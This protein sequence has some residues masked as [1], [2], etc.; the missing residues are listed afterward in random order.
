L[1]DIDGTVVV[2]V[3]GDPDTLIQSGTTKID[4]R[5][6]LIEEVIFPE[7]VIPQYLI[8]AAGTA[9]VV[10]GNYP[11][12]SG[13]YTSITLPNN[14]N[15][16]E[17]TGDV[18]IYVTGNLDMANHTFIKINAGSSLK[19]YIDG[20]ISSG[21]ECSFYNETLIPANFKI[22][23]TSTTSQSFDL[24]PNTDFYGVIYAPNADIWIQPNGDW[25]GACMC[26]SF[27]GSNNSFNF[28]YDKALSSIEYG[29]PVY[30]AVARWWED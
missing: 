8:D 22:F 2:G 3:G 1:I 4:E 12:V 18:E 19:I 6:A 9:L 20:N 5:A 24:W 17:I 13:K 27:Y 11:L 10:D 7:I 14:S 28:Y 25:F 21:P 26:N 23:G 15:T 30:F 29:D 16:L